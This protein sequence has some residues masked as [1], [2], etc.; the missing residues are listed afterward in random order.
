MN[1]PKEQGEKCEQLKKVI[2]AANPE[3]LQQKCTHKLMHDENGC[4]FGEHSRPIRLADVL[5]VVHKKVFG[6]HETVSLPTAKPLLDVVME[7]NLKD[8]NLD[9]QSDECK[10]FLIGLLV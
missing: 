9:H 8:D 3:I 7:W 2:Q 6:K 10:Q 1:S 4:P 5:L